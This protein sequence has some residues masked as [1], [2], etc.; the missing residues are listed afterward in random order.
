MARLPDVAAAGLSSS[1]P[2][3]T[4]GGDVHDD[5]RRRPPA[6]KRPERD[7]PRGDA[8]R[9]PGLL[10][11]H[12]AASAQRTP[13]HPSR[14]GRQPG[15]RRGHETFAREVFGGEP[16]V[17]Q[18]LLFGGR[19]GSEP[20]EVVGVVADIQYQGLTVG[21]SGAEVY[22]S[23]HQLKAS[24]LFVFPQPFIVV[25]TTGDPLGGASLPA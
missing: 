1:L 8:H 16:A 25:R 10:R 23:V 12:A 18:R 5:A 21:E 9:E 19:G 13:L 7:A 3:A 20:W 11:R 2:L 22:I 24:P 14:R 6:A 17:G 4:T 15:R